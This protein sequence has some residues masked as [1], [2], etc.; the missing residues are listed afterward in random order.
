VIDPGEFAERQTAAAAAMVDEIGAT[1]WTRAVL[2]VRSFGFFS[3]ASATLHRLDGTA[4]EIAAPVEAMSILIH[5]RHAMADEHGAWL[6]ATLTLN[7][8]FDGAVDFVVDFNYDARPDWQL[9]PDDL[10]Y[11]EDLR[12]YPRPAEEI[13]SW[14]PR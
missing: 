12:R 3:E 9:E 5:L 6:S 13:P 14:Y 8:T 10:T 1:A 2:D 4:E 11:V 7:R